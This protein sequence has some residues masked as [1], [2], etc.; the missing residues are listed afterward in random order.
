M[1]AH[2]QGE[3]SV[4]EVEMLEEDDDDEGSQTQ[5]AA[6][7]LLP[8]KQSCD[9]EKHLTRNRKLSKRTHFLLPDGWWVEPVGPRTGS[10]QDRRSSSSSSSSQRAV[11][12]LVFGE[13]VLG[14]PELFPQG[15]HFL[16]QSRV[17]LLQEGGP[18]GDLVL[19]EPAGVAGP[20]G[21]HVVLPATGPVFIILLERKNKKNKR[22]L[23]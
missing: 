17:L 3:E 16:P 15:G 13:D 7:E 22:G 1:G 9:A 12:G 10:N 18:D 8:W 14:A 19:L 4:G 21:S 5:F 20:L 11:L 2:L 23:T 6:G